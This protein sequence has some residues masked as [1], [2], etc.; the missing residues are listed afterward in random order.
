MRPLVPLVCGL[1]P[2]V[3]TAQATRLDHGRLDPA[4]FGTG[5]DFERS[6]LVYY[7][8]SRPGLSIQ[9]RTLHLRSWEAPAWLVKPRPEQDQ[10]FLK[11]LDPILIPSLAE[12]LRQEFR[13][14]A[15]VSLEDGDLALTGRVTDCR[16]SGVG[17][18]FGGL[19]GIYFDLKLTDVRTGEC[20]AAVH[21]FIEGETAESIQTRYQAWCRVFGR[22]LA[23]RGLKGLP[24]APLAPLKAAAPAAPAQPAPPAPS[25]TITADLEAALRRLEALRKDGL[26]TE[27]EFQTLRKQ[28]VER[29][30]RR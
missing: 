6:P 7:L 27:E 24:P 4:W 23:Q 9:G 3:L 21:H 12:G 28:A 20:L 10:A 25:G 2:I 13:G 19:A 8:W 11:H 29:A 22:V 16:S 26:I 17:G 15:A 5:I 30:A 14:S 1:F 18:L